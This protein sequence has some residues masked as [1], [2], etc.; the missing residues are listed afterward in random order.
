MVITV[1]VHPR[2][3]RTKAEWNGSQL[4]LWVTAAPVHGAANVAVLKAVAAYLHVPVTA[5]TLRSGAR[6]R[7]KLVEVRSIQ[8]IGVPPRPTTGSM[9]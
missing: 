4:E 5:V 2:A 8:T 1:R 6:G 7:T 3:T 9:N